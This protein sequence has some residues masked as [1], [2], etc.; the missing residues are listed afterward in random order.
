MTEHEDHDQRHCPDARANRRDQLVVDFEGGRN[1]TIWLGHMPQAI[2][3]A[4]VVA[5]MG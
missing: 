1:L 4:Q 5:P 3:A 2:E